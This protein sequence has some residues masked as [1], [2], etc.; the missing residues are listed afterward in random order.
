M[1]WPR[2][3]PHWHPAPPEAPHVMSSTRPAVQKTTNT[4]TCVRVQCNPLRACAC[5]CIR[6]FGVHSVCLC[7]AWVCAWRGRVH[8]SIAI[9][10]A[11]NVSLSEPVDAARAP[12]HVPYLRNPVLPPMLNCRSQRRARQ[13]RTCRRQHPLL[14]R[15]LLLLALPRGEAAGDA[16]VGNPA[17]RLLL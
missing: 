4:V 6:V 12:C 8:V 2:A 10:R 1:P 5:C 11:C 15:L 13:P 3:P 7:M 16:G 17:H 9:A 14:P